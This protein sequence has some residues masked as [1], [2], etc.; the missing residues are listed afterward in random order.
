MRRI[1]P[2]LRNIRRGISPRREGVAT[3]TR[4]QETRTVLTLN[5]RSMTMLTKT[6]IALAVALVLGGASVALADTDFD[7][8]LANRYP[9]YNEPVAVQGTSLSARGHLRSAPVRLQNVEPFSY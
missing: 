2:Y 6:K 3:K 1:A 9:A 5:S 7:P 8:N 4:L